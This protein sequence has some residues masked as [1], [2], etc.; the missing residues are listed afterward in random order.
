MSGEGEAGRTIRLTLAYEGTDFAGWHRQPGERTIQAAVEDA[1]ATIDERP[2]G[3]VAAGRTDAGVHALAQVA[4]ARVVNQLPPAVLLR[5]INVRLPPDVRVTAIADAPPRFNA[6]HDARAKVYQYT[7]AV[8]DDPGPFVR[9]VVWHVPGRLDV[10]AMARAASL[11]VGEH[12]FAA[13]QAAGGDVKTSVRRLLASALVDAPGPPRYVRYTATGTGFLRHMVRNIVG[14][15]AD[16]GRHRWPA[17]DI[18]DILASRSRHRAGVTAPP[19]GLVLAKV[20][21]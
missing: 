14:T 15:L 21:Y 11:L 6:R 3:V 17:E 1:L 13:F 20:I 8:G 18:L 10:P 12:D 16:I 19:Q 4:S 9:R 2:V 7:M 5:A